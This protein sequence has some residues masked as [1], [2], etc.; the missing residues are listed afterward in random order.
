[1]KRKKLFLKQNRRFYRKKETSR[2]DQKN[3]N[4]WHGIHLAL[5]KCTEIFVCL[6]FKKESEAGEMVLC[7]RALVLLE[8][9][10]LVPST[11][12]AASSHCN[13]SSRGFSAHSDPS[14]MW[15]AYLHAG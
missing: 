10:G 1:M 15:Y 6:F 14:H 9:L 7:L 5:H 13:F 2:R 4:Q 3:I 12:I 11:H 8:D